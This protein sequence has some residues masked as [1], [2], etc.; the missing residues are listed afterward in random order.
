MSNFLSSPDLQAQFLAALFSLP[1][2]GLILVSKEIGLKKIVLY[3]GPFTLLPI[4]VCLFVCKG[5]PE[6]FLWILLWPLIPYTLKRIL[7]PFS[8]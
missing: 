6:I 7:F 4:S 5:S 8:E 3:V 1:F 2:W